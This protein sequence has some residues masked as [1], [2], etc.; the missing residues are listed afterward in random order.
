MGVV[1]HMLWSYITDLRSN[2]K[3]GIKVGNYFVNKAV[4]LYQN[5]KKNN[6]TE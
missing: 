3:L 4:T 6:I 5:K 1:T 2:V